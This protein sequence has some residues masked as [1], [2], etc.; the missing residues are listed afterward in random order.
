MENECV[1]LPPRYTLALPASYIDGKR[2][3]GQETHCSMTG[4]ALPEDRRHC[5]P[6]TGTHC[7][8]TGDTLLDNRRKGKRCTM[9]AYQWQRGNAKPRR[10]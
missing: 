9:V 3:T 8:M 1:Y 10:A 5:C 7:P 4:D 2:H 6:R